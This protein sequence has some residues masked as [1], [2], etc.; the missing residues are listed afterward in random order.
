MV[1]HTSERKSVLKFKTSFEGPLPFF[2]FF[3]FLF[4]FFF[5]NDLKNISSLVYLNMLYLYY[6]YIINF[7]I[8]VILSYTFFL[9]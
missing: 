7:A 8:C 3:V 4:F 2:F 9:S 5:A 1:K 6:I